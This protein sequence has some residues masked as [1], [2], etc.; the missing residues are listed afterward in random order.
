MGLS[1]GLD[2]HEG[3]S[4]PESLNPPLLPFSVMISRAPELPD[5]DPPAVFHAPP[6]PPPT[7]P[8]TLCTL[9]YHLLLAGAH[10][11]TGPAP[12]PRCGP[13]PPPAAPVNSRALVC[14]FLH[15]LLRLH[16]GTTGRP[17]VA[18]GSEHVWA[19]S[20]MV[21]SILIPRSRCFGV[22]CLTSA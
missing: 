3:A 9:S 11:L 4:G 18:G 17:R 16:G 21:F 19:R 15:F 1:R 8:S 6:H 22:Y 20:R 10:G 14:F 7:L 12:S 13:V 5:A 2:R